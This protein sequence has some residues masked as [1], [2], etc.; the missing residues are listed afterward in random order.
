MHKNGN[1]PYTNVSTPPL[2]DGPIDNSANIDQTPF[3]YPTP[4]AYSHPP[5]TAPSF[6]AND[7]QVSAS[8]EN[9]IYPPS[10][11]IFSVE[12]QN[13]THSLDSNLDFGHPH[14]V[15][16]SFSIE[17]PNNATYNVSYT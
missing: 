6:D 13:P 17:T 11:D 4:P 1:S 12:N 2:D 16:S 9:Y 14:D 8:G 5:A 15:Y 3:F 7:H 10:G